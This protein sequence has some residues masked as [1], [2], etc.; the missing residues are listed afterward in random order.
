MKTYKS[1]IERVATLTPSVIGYRLLPFNLGHSIALK[2]AKSKFLN[3]AYNDF[4]DI[5]S[6]Y[7]A[8]VT[9]K[10]LVSEF[11]FAVLVCSTTYDDFREEVNNGSF[12]NTL[13]EV[14][15]RLKEDKFDIVQ[16]IHC[17]ALYLQQGTDA[18]LY[19]VKKTDDNEVV[20]DSPIDPEE[21]ILSTLMSDCGY[22]RNECLNLPMTE[23]LSAY[24][25]YAHK[26]GSI[27]LRSKAMND[28]MTKG[29]Q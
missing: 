17:F 14:V 26:M 18:P 11:V 2:S 1:Y 28:L 9:D 22:T 4:C 27:I 3:G 7:K 10:T 5:N 13:E 19:D 29:K 8:V 21:N 24:L 6:I 23:T 15:E 12:V 20:A 16:E 25:L